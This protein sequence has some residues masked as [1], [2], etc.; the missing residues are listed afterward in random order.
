MMSERVSVKKRVSET[1]R[2]LNFTPV[3]SKFA[4]KKDFKR[5]CQILVEIEKSV[6]LF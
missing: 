1:D 5:F 6:D 4:A 3:I 2:S